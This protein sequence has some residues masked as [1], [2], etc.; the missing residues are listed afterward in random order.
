VNERKLDAA[1]IRL[2]AN[3]GCPRD[4]FGELFGY[5]HP[6]N[7]TFADAAKVERAFVL[8]HV[9]DSGAEALRRRILKVADYFA[10]RVEPEHERIA[11]D[12]R[13]QEVRQTP[14][15]FLQKRMRFAKASRAASRRLTS[16]SQKNVAAI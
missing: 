2:R 5:R 15:D 9:G 16:E 6:S 3:L 11:L 12:V 8:D 1:S 7:R 10:I 13:L 14:D 4:Y